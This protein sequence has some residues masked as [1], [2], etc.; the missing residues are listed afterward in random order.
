[1]GFIDDSMD[2]GEDEE[3][4][5]SS[6]KI[7]T[8]ITP[9]E[10]NTILEKIREVFPQSNQQFVREFGSNSDTI[11]TYT[12]R[13]T[14][15]RGIFIRPLD[16]YELLF[17]LKQL[18]YLDNDFESSESLGIQTGGKGKTIDDFYITVY[19][20]SVETGLW[21]YMRDFIEP[22]R[23]V[24]KRKREAANKAKQQGIDISKLANLRTG[25]KPGSV[26]VP[27]VATPVQP[28]AIP[29]TLGGKKKTRR[30]KNRSKSKKSKKQN[31]AK[32]NKTK[33][34]K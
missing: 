34:K 20:L 8:T 27:P 22:E 24:Q 15:N 23:I 2:T 3:E 16:Y 19:E 25:F 28:A 6:K 1:M 32:K 17:I 12:Y 11:N 31:K 5:E 30:R 4:G 14:N 10:E 26:P 33:R 13:D 29:A 7:K 21:E 9:D 18:F